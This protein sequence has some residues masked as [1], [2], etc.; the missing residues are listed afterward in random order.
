MLMFRGQAAV[1]LR[2]IEVS[3]SVNT[4]TAAG[5]MAVAD[6]VAPERMVAQRDDVES[7]SPAFF[8]IAC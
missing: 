2:L 1:I 5:G 3:D 4:C 6:L 7:A 8:V